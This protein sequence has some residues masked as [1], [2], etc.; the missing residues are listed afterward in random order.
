[1]SHESELKTTTTTL[2]EPFLKVCADP[3]GSKILSHRRMAG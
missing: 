1:M 3:D 2:K